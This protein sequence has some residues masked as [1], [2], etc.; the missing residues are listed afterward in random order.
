M[1]NGQKTESK[2]PKPKYRKL[3]FRKQQYRNQNTERPEYRKVKMPKN[4]NIE[5]PKYRKIKMPNKYDK[6]DNK[7]NAQN[8]GFGLYCSH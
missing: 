3:K 6:K 5:C 2:R 1:P 4:Q 7:R 8:P